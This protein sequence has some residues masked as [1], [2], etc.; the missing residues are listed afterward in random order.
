MKRALLGILACVGLALVFGEGR[1]EALSFTKASKIVTVTITVTPS[2]APV[3][4]RATRFG[5]AAYHPVPVIAQSQPQGRAPVKMVTK[6]DPN[7]QYLHYIPGAGNDALTVPYGLSTWPCVFQIYAQ[8]PTK[9]QLNDWA[10]GT[11]TGGTSYFPLMN[12]PT[13]S[14]LSW[15]AQPPATNNN[16]GVFTTFYNNG[17]PGQLTSQSAAGGSQQFC[18]DLQINVPN[19]QAPGTYTAPIQYVLTV[20]Q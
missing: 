2:P 10:F 1:V 16:G 7:A 19:S 5:F 11:G 14:Y 6:V 20:F 18:V 8:Y 15:L 17:T 13:P 3:A 4:F 9:W 12:S